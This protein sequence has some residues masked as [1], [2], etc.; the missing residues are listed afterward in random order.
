MSLTRTTIPLA[1]FSTMYPLLKYHLSSS[2]KQFLP[3]VP[4]FSSNF[5]PLEFPLEC[6]AQHC[7]HTTITICLFLAEYPLQSIMHCPPQVLPLD[8]YFSKLFSPLNLHCRNLRYQC[9]ASKTLRCGGR[10]LRL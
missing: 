1:T 9:L 4:Y 3:L 10:S 8:P 7:D 2:A 5:S 6:Y